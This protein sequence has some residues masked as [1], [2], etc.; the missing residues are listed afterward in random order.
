[1]FSVPLVFERSLFLFSREG[2]GGTGPDNGVPS[3]DQDW[4]RKIGDVLLCT[5]DVL[6]MDHYIKYLDAHAA[7]LERLEL[8]V[9]QDT[10]YS[11]ILHLPSTIFESMQ[12]QDFSNFASTY[13]KYSVRMFQTP[14][15]PVLF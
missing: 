10:R 15:I 8:A 6:T 11:H 7:I 5:F 3:S 14:R 1:M 13:S 12:H 2:R 4:S 9:M